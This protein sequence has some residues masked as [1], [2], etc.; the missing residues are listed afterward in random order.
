MNYEPIETRIEE[1]WN[2]VYNRGLETP[3]ADIGDWFSRS[4][5]GTYDFRHI[6]TTYNLDQTINPSIDVNEN[7]RTT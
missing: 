7:G 3:T 5:L 1:L 6:S 4:S 2:N